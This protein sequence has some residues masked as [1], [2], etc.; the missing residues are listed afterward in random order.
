MAI[1][2]KEYKSRALLGEYRTPQMVIWMLKHSGG[3][4]KTER[5][6]AYMLV[7][8]ILFTIIAVPYIL[9]GVIRITEHPSMYGPAPQMMHPNSNYPR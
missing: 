5:Q 3:L 8:F 7:G 9:L 6:A 4:L 2:H 1:H